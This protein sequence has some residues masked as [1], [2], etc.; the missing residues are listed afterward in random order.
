MTST[1]E[2]MLEELDKVAATQNKAEATGNAEVGHKRNRNSKKKSVLC[3][4]TCN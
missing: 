1:P 2:D 4:L 3:D